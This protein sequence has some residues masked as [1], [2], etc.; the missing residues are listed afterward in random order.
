MREGG[1]EERGGEGKIGLNECSSPQFFQ[2]NLQEK[3]QILTTSY[4]WNKIMKL[5]VCYHFDIIKTNQSIKDM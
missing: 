1:G 2:T 5:N 4:K 3:S